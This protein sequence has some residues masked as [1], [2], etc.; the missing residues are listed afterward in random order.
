[1]DFQFNFLIKNQRPQLCVVQKFT[2]GYKVC[3]SFSRRCKKYSF[4]Y[5][6]SYNL[7]IYVAN[8]Y[9]KNSTHYFN[10]FKQ[11]PMLGFY[12]IYAICTISGSIGLLCYKT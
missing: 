4:L 6:K 1:M 10:Y 5:F 7:A 3:L 2:R 11:D 9:E 8:F 12:S